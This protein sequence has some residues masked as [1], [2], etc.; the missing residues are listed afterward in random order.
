MQLLALFQLFIVGLMFLHEF[1]DA[2]LGEGAEQRI[3]TLL[4][5]CFV[6]SR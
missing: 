1:E 2:V 4:R 5:K 3:F 6:L